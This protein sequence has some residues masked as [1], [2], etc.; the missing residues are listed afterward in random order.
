MT[1]ATRN[2]AI[3]DKPQTDK[4]KPFCSAR[5]ADIDLHRWMKGSYAIPGRPADEDED[6]D[7]AS[8]QSPARND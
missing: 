3:C 6:G 5:C 2:C 4:F 7:H 1:T 8:A